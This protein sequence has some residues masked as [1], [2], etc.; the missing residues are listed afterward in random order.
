MLVCLLDGIQIGFR[1][2][3]SRMT[4]FIGRMIK[5]FILR[6]RVVGF[7]RRDVSG[8]VLCGKRVVIDIRIEIAVLAETFNLGKVYFVSAAYVDR[9]ECT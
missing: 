9:Y 4:S 8:N 1:W 5:G 7:A 2:C 3:V 6:Q